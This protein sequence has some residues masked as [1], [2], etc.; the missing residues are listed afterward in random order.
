MKSARSF[1]IVLVTVPDLKTARALVRSTLKARLVACANLVASVESHYW[2]HEKIEKT[3]EVLL[4]LKTTRARLPALEK[5]ILRE[6]PYDTA[7]ILVVPLHLG[8]SR[9]LAWLE[10]S[11]RLSAR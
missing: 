9:Y 6:H 3:N 7:E 1:A 11:V 10:G 4:V 5:L 2:W 8:T